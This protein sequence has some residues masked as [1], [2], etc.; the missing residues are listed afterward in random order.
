M[1]TEWPCQCFSVIKG[2][3]IGHTDRPCE[4]GGLSICKNNSELAQQITRP[5]LPSVAL[6][7]ITGT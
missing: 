1:D 2:I 3:C 4:L 7:D 6:S 5:A